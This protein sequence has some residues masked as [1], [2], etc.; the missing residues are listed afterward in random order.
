MAAKK[1]FRGYV[2]A[3]LNRIIRAVTALKNGDRDW[4]LSDVLTEALE[5][6]LAKP[7]NRALIEKH[8]LGDFQDADESD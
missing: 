4:S 1:E 3:D 2:P 6:W 7:E 5:D 8:N